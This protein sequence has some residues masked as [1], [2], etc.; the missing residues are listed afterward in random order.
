MVMFP[1]KDG[2]PWSPPKPLP[3]EY[4][5]N[6]PTGFLPPGHPGR[7][8]TRYDVPRNLWKYWGPCSQYLMRRLRSSGHREMPGPLLAGHYCFRAA[9]HRELNN[10]PIYQ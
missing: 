10:C 6:T 8:L 4:V 5:G 1:D 3:P 7:E 2:T 9:V